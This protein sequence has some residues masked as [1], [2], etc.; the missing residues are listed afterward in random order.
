[1]RH[2]PV[3]DIWV[4]LKRRLTALEKEPLHYIPNLDDKPCVQRCR[5]QHNEPRK[6]SLSTEY[7]HCSKL[8]VS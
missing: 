4:K 5:C 7:E 2:Q 8:L 6:A 3:Q 1:M